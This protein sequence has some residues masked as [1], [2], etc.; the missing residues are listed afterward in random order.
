MGETWRMGLYRKAIKFLEEANF[1]ES[2]KLQ[3]RLK[4]S[5]LGFLMHRALTNLLF[6]LTI[7]LMGFLTGSSLLLV[8]WQQTQPIKYLT[9][10][11]EFLVWLTLVSILFA[12]LPL[13][14]IYGFSCLQKLR[15]SRFSASSLGSLAIL[16][17]LFFV[18][19]LMMG[20]FPDVFPEADLPSFRLRVGIIVLF[21]GMCAT[22][23][24]VS[25]A[26]LNSYI[27]TLSPQKA[28]F[29]N[30]YFKVRNQ[31]DGLFGTI[32][33]IIGVGTL[34][35]G[36]LQNALAA[37]YKASGV[38]TEGIFPPIHTVVYGGYF[39]VI[40]ILLYVPLEKSMEELARSFIELHIQLPN[41]DSDSWTSVYEKRKKAEEWLKLTTPLLNIKSGLAVL[42]PLV[43]G[44][45]SYIIP[46]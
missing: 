38:I 31:L 5:L 32:G 7:V 42:T 41:L 39:S 18:P 35:T 46:K 44:L 43:G 19:Y 1:E 26:L 20:N 4:I 14:A 25:I 23:A 16:L 6:P 22:P 24:A 27:Q 21:C 34:A 13:C 8:G 30:E 3:R 28:D 17:I 29:L 40:L 9:S 45:I 36:G 15:I 37:F 10:T 12:I 2:T 33:L 11:S